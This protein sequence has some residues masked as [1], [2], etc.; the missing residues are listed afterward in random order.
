M[1]SSPTTVKFAVGDK[2]CLKPEW[3]AWGAVRGFDK[4]EFVTIIDFNPHGHEGPVA[5]F[6]EISRGQGAFVHKL[7]PPSGPW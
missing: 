5:F 7:Q 1:P 6:A 3:A 4:F 2:V